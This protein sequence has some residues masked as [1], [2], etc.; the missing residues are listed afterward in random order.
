MSD[1]ARAFAETKRRVEAAREE[2]L[3]ALAKEQP[4]A[5]LVHP[6]LACWTET[7]ANRLFCDSGCL[8]YWR[9]TR[10]GGAG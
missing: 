9:A 1:G 3:A 10:T 4:P 7:D 2:N 5:G 6:C 8:A